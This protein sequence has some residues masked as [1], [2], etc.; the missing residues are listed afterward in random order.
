MS[1]WCLIL[2]DILVLL[3]FFNSRNVVKAILESGTKEYE[4]LFQVWTQSKQETYY[5]TPLKLLIEHM[6]GMLLMKAFNTTC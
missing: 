6:P 4:M 1:K 3:F 2:Q 5:I